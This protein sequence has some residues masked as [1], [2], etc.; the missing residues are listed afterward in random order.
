MRIALATC[1][2]LPEWEVDDDALRQALH[3]LDVGFD[4]P[5]WDDASIAWSAFDAVVV[6]TTWDYVAKAHA[7]REWLVR[8]AAATRLLNPIDVVLWNLDKRYLRDL[9]ERGVPTVPT[10]WL[11]A[12]GGTVA[13]VR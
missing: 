8:C 1:S 9:A 3:A 7:F 2:G 6:R 4:E 5:A 13:V 11:D 12:A 10:L